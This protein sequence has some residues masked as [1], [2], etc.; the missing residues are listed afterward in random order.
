MRGLSRLKGGTVL[1][2]EKPMSKYPE[3]QI[4]NYAHQLWEKAGRPEGKCEEFWR[5]AE[6]EL[7]AGGE[8]V[9]PGDQPNAS[10][11]PG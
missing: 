11:I 4:R 7:D 3:E 6:N 8:G 9:D 2:T 1:L 5:Q 10:T